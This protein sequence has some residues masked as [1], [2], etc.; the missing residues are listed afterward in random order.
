MLHERPD[1]LEYLIKQGEEAL[2]EASEAAIESPTEARLEA[3]MHEL[4]SL[5]Y[6]DALR[7]FESALYIDP[8]N[9]KALEGFCYSLAKAISHHEHSGLTGIAETIKLKALPYCTD[10]ALEIA[11]SSP[12]IG[13][14]FLEIIRDM[15][16]IR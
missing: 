15:F 1:T 16:M 11:E 8:E 5:N 7:S 3:L 9:E 2:N 10:R 6:H 12:R 4:L 14:S 13:R